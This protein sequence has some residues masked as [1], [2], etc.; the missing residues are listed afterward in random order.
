MASFL[1]KK[2]AVKLTVDAEERIRRELEN[3]Q[4]SIREISGGLVIQSASASGI[5]KSLDSLAGRVE[6]HRESM[7]SMKGALESVATLYEKAEKDICGYTE[8]IIKT[9]NLQTSQT[10]SSLFSGLASLFGKIADGLFSPLKTVWNKYIWPGIEGILSSIVGKGDVTDRQPT[11]SWAGAVHKNLMAAVKSAVDK[12][13]ADNVIADSSTAAGVAPKY[14]QPDYT[15]KNLAPNKDGIYGNYVYWRDG[16]YGSVEYWNIEGIQLSCTYY[17]L[18]R[19]NERGLSYP[20]VGGP[21]HGKSWY[22]N[23]DRDS[24]LPHY[25]GT[26]ALKDLSN[27]LTLPQANIV[28]S[29]DETSSN[30]YGH[31]LLID[32]I[33]RD[34]TGTVRVKYSD[35]FYNESGK[36]TRYINSLNGNNP[37]LDITL[38]E[39]MDDYKKTNGPIK[40]AAVIGAGN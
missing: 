30:E 19:L 32:E 25:A 4:Q 35:M 2:N 27:N 17:T 40:G 34:G 8:E 21:G 11:V 38:D 16:R 3:I 15:Q 12:V 24:G 7:G 36:E 31:V 37:Q 10:G 33:Y 26:N 9:S 22:G 5:K 1:F 28:V 18:R 23:F 6:F 13:A 29:F 14:K 39:F 20:C